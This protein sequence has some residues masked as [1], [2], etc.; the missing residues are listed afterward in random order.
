MTNELQ[1]RQERPEWSSSAT[2]VNKLQSPFFL[3][4]FSH[5]VDPQS[6]TKEE[7][8]VKRS[9]SQ[10]GNITLWKQPRLITNTEITQRVF[11]DWESHGFLTV[12]P[13][14]YPC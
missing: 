9:P 4:S 1:W 7:E 13:F 14:N 10:F 5:P 3:S 6:N 12:H 11:P 2:V 8:K